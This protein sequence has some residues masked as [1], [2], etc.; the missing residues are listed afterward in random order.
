MYTIQHVLAGISQV[1]V[2]IGWG[3]I[4]PTDL[5]LWSA[6]CSAY[7]SFTPKTNALCSVDT[8]TPPQ[9]FFLE[10]V[11]NVWVVQALQSSLRIWGFAVALI[12]VLRNCSRQG[13]C[14]AGNPL[15]SVW[16][17]SETGTGRDWDLPLQCCHWT[18]HLRQHRPVGDAC[19]PV[20]ICLLASWQGFLAFLLQTL[21]PA[22][23]PL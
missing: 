13:I 7:R 5:R 1:V 11:S 15:V 17:G 19:A 18:F 20:H 14:S 16:P 3:N 6:M 8:R 12:R 23:F 2:T 9:V 21:L 10:R 4:I 22:L